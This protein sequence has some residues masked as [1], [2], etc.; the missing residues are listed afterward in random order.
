M[1]A[2]LGLQVPSVVRVG[3]WGTFFE[4][5][6][7]GTVACWGWLGGCG[8]GACRVGIILIVWLVV[9]IGGVV[10]C[11]IVKIIIFGIVVLTFIIFRSIAM[12]MSIIIITSIIVLP[13]HFPLI[14]PKMIMHL[15]HPLTPIDIR[16]PTIFTLGQSSTH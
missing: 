7:F 14:L 6:E 1:L 4:K 11:R 2:M 3:E 13:K 9:V 5:E 16:T 8:G 12:L 10:L 15:P